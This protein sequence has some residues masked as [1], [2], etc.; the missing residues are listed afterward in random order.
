MEGYCL[1]IEGCGL[2]AIF[3]GWRLCVLWWLKTGRWRVEVDG[4]LWLLRI[5][6]KRLWKAF[7][8]EKTIV[9][10]VGVADVSGK[11]EKLFGRWRVSLLT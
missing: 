9:T 3:Y 4:G 8:S 5:V 11:E 2:F 10:I 1:V 6:E 7:A